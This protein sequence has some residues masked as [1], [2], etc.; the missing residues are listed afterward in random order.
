MSDAPLARHLLIPFAGRASPDCRATMAA[1]KLPNLEALHERLTLAHTDAQDEDSFSP[2]HERA[3]AEALGLAAPD[4]LLPWAA[5]AAR[6]AGLPDADGQGWGL[7]TLC[8]WQVGLDDVVLGDPAEIALDAAESDALLAAARPLFESDGFALYPGEHPGHWLA[9][10]ALFAQLPTASV[11]RAAGQSIAQWTPQTEEA[12]PLRR[13]QT[14]VQ[15]LLYTERV[16][17]ERTARGATPIN[18]FWLSGTGAQPTHPSEAAMPEVDD[19]QRAAARRDDGPAWAAAWQALDAGPVA[20]L[21]A[22]SLRGAD[23]TLTL[24]GD[25]AA[26]RLTTRKRGLGRLVKQ[27]FGRPG[28]AALL[29]PL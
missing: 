22:D 28:A 8:H 25:R 20:A 17:D 5:L 24:C 6:R 19:R 2:P 9:R 7:L 27:L 10:G 14:E 29:E 3:L 13:L 4:G 11:D 23:V 18:S 16:N 21:L 12:R 26:Q 15:M 1:L